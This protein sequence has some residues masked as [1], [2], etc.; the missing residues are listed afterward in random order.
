MFKGD[1]YIPWSDKLNRLKFKGMNR[2]KDNSH[3]ILL[4][5]NKDNLHILQTYFHVMKYW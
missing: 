3:L 5:L 1:Q 4:I 2:G